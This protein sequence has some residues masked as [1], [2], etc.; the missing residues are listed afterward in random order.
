MDFNK[1]RPQALP[2][3]LELEQLPRPANNCFLTEDSF[4]VFFIGGSAR[5]G[6]TLDQELI[7]CKL[8]LSRQFDSVCLLGDFQLVVAAHS[9]GWSLS[10]R[11]L[12]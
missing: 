8:G 11:L 4:A 12:F 3:I 6:G 10:V 9:C 1:A 7:E 5:T 2:T